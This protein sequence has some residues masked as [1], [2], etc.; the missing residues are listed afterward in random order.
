MG[1]CT[2]YRYKFPLSARDPVKKTSQDSIYE[3]NH[4]YKINHAFDLKNPHFVFSKNSHFSYQYHES[5]QIE[6]DSIKGN[7]SIKISSREIFELNNLID[8]YLS[9]T[10]NPYN[11]LVDDNNDFYIPLVVKIEYNSIK[12]KK[13]FTIY[14]LAIRVVHKTMINVNEKTEIQKFGFQILKN[15]VST[16]TFKIK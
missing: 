4:T 10:Y 8:S 9:Y 15:V 13:Y 1:I 2:P 12:N 14:D 7:H 11:N 16:N 6:R 5:F 3:D